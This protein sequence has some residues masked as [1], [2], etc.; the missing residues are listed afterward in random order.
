MQ[1]KFNLIIILLICFNF[2]CPAFF[3]HNTVYAQ[4]PLIKYEGKVE[5]FFTHCLIAY[6]ELAFAEDNFMK[7]DYDIDCLT[8]Y[9]LNKILKSLYEK[10]YILVKMSDIYKIK[11]NK[12]V[13]SP[14][15]LPK[16]KKPFVFSFDDVNYDTK[17]INKGMVDKIILDENNE[18]ATYTEHTPDDTH[19]SYDK[20]FINVLAN[21]IHKHPDFAHKGAKGL[22]CLTGYD[23]ILGYRTDLIGKNRVLEIE[24]VK[25]VIEK[26]KQDGWEFASHSYGHYHMKNISLAKFKNEIIRFKDEVES[27]VGNLE[28]YA[29]PYGEYEISN[30]QAE[31]TKKHLLLEEAGFKIFCGV[32]SKYFF[33]LAAFNMNKKDRVLFMDRRPFDGN[34]L[35]NN[36]KRYE[37]F[38]NSEEVYDHKH[39]TVPFK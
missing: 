25:P 37:Q 33:G 7:K 11:N 31:K 3:T 21:F 13:K 30:Q 19:I 2:C 1:P 4:N 28:V 17:K 5:H 22:I 12:A 9:E 16:G 15:Y 34:N 36:K 38:F 20:E 29:Y 18:L 24:K 10:N 27:L 23:G 32:G 35:R 39:R 6:P 14:L 8:S 26:L